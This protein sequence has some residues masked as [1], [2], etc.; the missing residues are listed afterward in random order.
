MMSL[1]A[2]LGVEL[3]A[4]LAVC[5]V[6]SAGSGFDQEERPVIVF[7]PT[8]SRRMRKELTIRQ[9]WRYPSSRGPIVGP[10]IR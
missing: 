4:L 1:A 6:E 3:P 10:P 9:L 2:N 5:D 7:S 8:V